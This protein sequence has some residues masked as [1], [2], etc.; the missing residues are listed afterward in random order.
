[1]FFYNDRM[2][3]QKIVQIVYGALCH[4]IGTPEQVAS[5]REIV[6]MME[7]FVNLKKYCKYKTMVSGG[8]KEGFRLS[9]SDLA[10]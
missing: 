2:S 9:D 7:L 4:M 10:R 6:D 3:L 5:R 1:M 8:I